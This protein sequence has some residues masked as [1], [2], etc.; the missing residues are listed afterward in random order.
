MTGTPNRVA[1]SDPFQ[2]PYRK[3][4]R[5]LHHLDALYD[6]LANYESSQP[7]ETFLTPDSEYER[8][9]PI[10][11]PPI[12][13]AILA[14]EVL[15]QVRSALDH[16]FFELVKKNRGPVI[17]SG[18]N[19]ERQCQFPIITKAPDGLRP[20]I[21]RDRFPSKARDWLSDEAF[22]HIESIQPYYAEK[23][24]SHALARLRDLSNIDKHR[25]LAVTIA[26]MDVTDSVQLRHGTISTT[27][28]MFDPGTELEPLSEPPEMPE[29]GLHIKRQLTPVVAFNEPIIGPPISA[30]VNDTVTEIWEVGAWITRNLGVLLNRP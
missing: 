2:S 28:L 22:E 27:R 9:Q 19:W 4:V 10:R 23:Y 26:K 29:F 20:P 16:L 6:C 14:G 15:Y 17:P 21:Q 11:E 1:A 5:A 13:I 25:R 24:H 30:R 7:Y 8:W 12:D 3:I 18:G